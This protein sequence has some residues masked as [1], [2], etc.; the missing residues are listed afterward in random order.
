MNNTTKKYFKFFLI[1][2]KQWLYSLI[3]KRGEKMTKCD[4]KKRIALLLI[5][6]KMIQDNPNKAIEC[7]QK[8]IKALED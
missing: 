6:V 4:K 3:R 7:I 5:I 1:W 2:L 8:Y